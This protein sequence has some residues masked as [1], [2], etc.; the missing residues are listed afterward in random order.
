MQGDTSP[1]KKWPTRVSRMLL[2]W[3]R[4]IALNREA[5]HKASIAAADLSQKLTIYL[6]IF[7][8]LTMV[9]SFSQI[10]ESDIKLLN[11][12]IRIT[13]AVTALVAGAITTAIA[14]LKPDE[15]AEK[16]RSTASQYADVSNKIQIASVM[17][18]Q[19]EHEG[20]LRSI[21][22]QFSSIQQNGPGLL[23]EYAST[24]DLPNLILMQIAQRRKANVIEESDKKLFVGGEDSLEDPQRKA[25][26]LFDS[27]SDLEISLSNPVTP[28]NERKKSSRKKTLAKIGESHDDVKREPKIF[29]RA[30]SE[31]SNPDS[32]SITVHVKDAISAKVSSKKSSNPEMNHSSDI[33]KDFVMAEVEIP[34]ITADKAA[35]KAAKIWRK[36]VTKPKARSKVSLEQCTEDIDMYARRTSLTPSSPIQD[37]RTSFLRKAKSGEGN[38]D[39]IDKLQEQKL[40]ELG[41]AEDP[42]YG[43]VKGNR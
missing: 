37:S 8:T 23:K 7:T 12:I 40:N 21:V 11:L 27:D 17:T 2:L 32:R 4:Q 16:H 38:T 26:G 20:F 18:R 39:L 28:R 6:I 33:E 43:F 29:L 9:S 5:H 14:K 35:K 10:F 42:V 19:P 36:S 25:T 3:L 31:T 1:R 15:E 30:D 24:A 13:A 22:E 41:I 34:N